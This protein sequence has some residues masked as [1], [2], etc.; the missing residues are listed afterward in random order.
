MKE[1]EDLCGR[2]HPSLLIGLDAVGKQQKNTPK[3]QLSRRRQTDIKVADPSQQQQ[4]QE[5][6]GV[7]TPV[8]SREGGNTEM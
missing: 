1:E 2:T 4:Q 7:M 5:A 3:H 8:R 6:P